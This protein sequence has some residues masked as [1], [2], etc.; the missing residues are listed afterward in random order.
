VHQGHQIDRFM[1][2]LELAL[3][4]ALHLQQVID[5]PLQPLHLLLYPGQV[6]PGPPIRAL[7]LQLPAQ[8]C[9]EAVDGRERGAQLVAD[10]RQELLTAP[11]RGCGP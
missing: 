4:Q 8:Q 11:V 6:A 10:Q 3:L 5:Q 9:E 2:Q 7:C 1:V